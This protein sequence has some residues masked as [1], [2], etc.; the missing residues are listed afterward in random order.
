MKSANRGPVVLLTDFGDGCFQGVMKGVI[1]SRAPGATIVD[2]D[3][4]VRAGAVLE[5]AYVLATA[6]RYFPVTSVFCC[7]VDPGVGTSRRRILVEVPGGQLAVGP[8]NGLLTPFLDAK[9]AVAREIT[10]QAWFADDDTRTFEGRSRFGPVAAELAAG[11]APR[12]AGPVIRDPVRLELA[13][14]RPTKAGVAGEVVYVDSFGNLVT[15]VMAA[16]LDGLAGRPDVLVSVGARRGIPLKGTYS[17][18]GIGKPVA[19][20]G[21]TG[22][23]EVGVRGG[24]ALLE[25]G[26]DVGAPVVVRSARKTRSPGLPV[27]RPEGAGPGSGS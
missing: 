10:N 26:L 16:D 1:L 17:E 27:R 6:A 21:S 3:H 9:G 18:V 13:R 12:M 20:V 11:A 19:Y 5:G 24:S 14:C 25:L 7:V 4:H 22:Y 23:V 8:D 2:L 15:S